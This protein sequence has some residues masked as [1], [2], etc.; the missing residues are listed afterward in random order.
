[1]VISRNRVQRGSGSGFGLDAASAGNCGGGSESG[2]GSENS[3][4]TSTRAL[5]YTMAGPRLRHSSR[6]VAPS[7]AIRSESLIVA[8]LPTPASSTRWSFASTT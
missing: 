5:T 4:F 3:A 6:P 7:S 1:M 8:P 2:S